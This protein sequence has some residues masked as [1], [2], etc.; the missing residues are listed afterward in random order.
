MGPGGRRPLSAVA[1]WPS[2]VA[3]DHTPVEFSV[4]LAQ[5][6]PPAVRMIVESL[7]EQP[8]RRENLD[9]ALGVLDRLSSRHRLHL[10]RFDRVRDLFLPADPQ[11]TFAFWYSLIVGP[12]AAPAIKVYLNPDVRGP[13]NGTALVTEALTR[14]GLSAALPAVR[15]H[16]LR[17]EGLDRFSFFA[18]DLMDEHRARV[19]TYVSHDDSVV[20][21]VVE[22]ASATPDVDLEL[23]ADV[24]ALA[25]GGTGPFTRRPLMSSYTFMSGDTDRPSGYSLYVPVR[26]YVQDDLEACERVLA[27]MARC[28]LDTAPFVMAL[29]SIVRRPLGEGVGLIAHVSLRLGRPRPGVT[30]YLSSEAYDVTPP[31]TEAMSV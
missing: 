16:A 9:A 30:V 27:I 21:D 19:K 24:V 7:A 8:G 18:L 13:E 22:A 5:N 15:E 20:A 25:C 2:S 26:D 12:Y 17:R 29:A 23:L 1:D 11:G 4:A 31:R 3:D 10:G 14:L 28:G 6:E